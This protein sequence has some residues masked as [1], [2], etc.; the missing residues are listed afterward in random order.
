M[1]FLWLILLDR[2]GMYSLWWKSQVGSDIG[3]R[4]GEEASGGE[5]AREA[6]GGDK[7]GQ[8]WRGDKTG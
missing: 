3:G 7:E 1:S 6:N 5:R 2:I 4:A 8:W